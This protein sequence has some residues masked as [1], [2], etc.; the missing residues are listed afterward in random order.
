MVP[1]LAAGAEAGVPAFPR[2]RKGK[3]GLRPRDCPT[4]QRGS[5]LRENTRA[6]AVSTSRRKRRLVPGVGLGLLGPTESTQVIGFR[7][8]QMR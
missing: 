8:S 3:N 7:L 1:S 2:H 6:I 5:G 4:V